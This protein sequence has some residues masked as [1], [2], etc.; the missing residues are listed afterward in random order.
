MSPS[1]LVL[2]KVATFLAGAGAGA[3]FVILIYGSIQGEATPSWLLPAGIVLATVGA[4]LQ[5]RLHRS[6]SDPGA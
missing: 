1:S 4:A 2:A 5:H 6:Q 3:C